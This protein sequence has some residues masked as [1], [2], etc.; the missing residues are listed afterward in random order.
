MVANSQKKNTKKS[1]NSSVKH[2]SNQKRILNDTVNDQ[3][4]EDEQQKRNEHQVKKSKLK[5]CCAAMQPYNG[6]A[7]NVRYK[8]PCAMHD[9]QND[10]QAMQAEEQPQAIQVAYYQSVTV[11]ESLSYKQYCNSSDLYGQMNQKNFASEEKNECQKSQYN[12]NKLH[13]N[14]GKQKNGI[15]EHN[16]IRRH[17]HQLQ[18]QKQHEQHESVQRYESQPSIE[19]NKGLIEN[20]VI[21][22]NPIS[23]G[24]IQN[25][26]VVSQNVHFANNFRAL[27]SK[28]VAT[29]INS[30]EIANNLAVNCFSGSERDA[31]NNT[32]QNMNANAE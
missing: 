31:K 16:Q 15:A 14:S 11:H 20:S 26:N 13:Q 29:N 2:V 23:P 8:L 30:F 6:N 12:H 10:Q 32:T 19:F 3:Q 18:K 21:I 17:P 7:D 5:N 28:C 22:P 9:E 1:D 4:Q 25:D 27:G 24:T